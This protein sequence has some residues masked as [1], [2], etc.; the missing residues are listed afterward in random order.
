MPEMNEYND[1]F[2]KDI[3]P[4]TKEKIILA[5]VENAV[6]ADVS[7]VKDNPESPIGKDRKGDREYRK[8]FFTVTYKLETPVN[9]EDE[10]FESYGFRFYE[11]KKEIWYG[12]K[13]K[14]ACGKLVDTLQ[15]YIKELPENP[16]P[17]EIKAVLLGKKVKIVS[18]EFGAAAMK[19]KKI[20]IASF[21]D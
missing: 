18:E 9:G 6:I 1:E 17:I 15:K 16:S 14:S 21:R 7:K 11:D 8:M 5:T 3:R 20:M 4:K 19:S 2:F 10:I 13:D 12:G